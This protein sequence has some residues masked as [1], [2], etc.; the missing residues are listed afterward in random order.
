MSAERRDRGP[1]RDRE[2][3]AEEWEEAAKDSDDV[4]GGERRMLLAE[5]RRAGSSAV[6]RR[7]V[8]QAG[9]WTVATVLAGLLGLLTQTLLADRLSVQE[10]AAFGFSLAFL[11]FVAL[12]FEF[13]LFVPA[14]RMAA[15]A[16]GVE[17]RRLL[18]SALYMYAPLGILF[19]AVIFVSSY[20]VDDIFE[21][22]A[23]AALRAAAP[24]S[25]AFP[26][27]FIGQQLAQGA[28]RLHV[29]SAG[30]LLAQLLTFAAVV[31]AIFVGPGIGAPG[32]VEL[33]AAGLL[34]AGLGVA[35]FLRPLFTRSLR[36]LGRFF[37]AAR[38]YGLAIYLGRV[39]SVGTFNV[40]ILML[41]A[42][43]DARTVAVY[44]IARALATFTSV[45]ADG[46]AAAV[47]PRMANRVGIPASD[48]RA[49]IAATFTSALGVVV[50]GSCLTVFVL[51]SAYSQLPLY[52]AILA[53]AHSLRGVGSLYSAYLSAQGIGRALRNA[54]LV[55]TVANVVLNAALIP[56]FGGVGAAVASVAA[57]AINLSVLVRGYRGSV[58]T[59]LA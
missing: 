21:V 54:G 38:E 20:F 22:E 15:R 32:A 43:S 3:D 37:T 12:F 18:G 1:K 28:D 44:T 6:G 45:P 30:A 7:G 41:A 8:R 2:L 57:L 47:F 23:S 17:R 24:F 13:G 11:Q 59:P 48:L 10:F 16:A 53:G 25:L 36:Q 14:S 4:D 19:A 29:A 58:S 27:V 39:L 42:L 9:F 50:I 56:L 34:I 46:I 49:V 35:A 31:L 52:V 26:F 51:P 40:D 33:R 55:L 5:L